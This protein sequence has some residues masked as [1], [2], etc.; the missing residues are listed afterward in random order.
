MREQ[1]ENRDVN[2]KQQNSEEIEEEEE[3]KTSKSKKKSKKGKKQEEQEEDELEQING[4]TEADHDERV[5]N[6]QKIMESFLDDSQIFRFYKGLT[7]NICQDLLNNL[8]SEQKQVRNVALDRVAVLSLIKFM[9]ISYK[10]CRENISYLFQLIDPKSPFANE[11]DN[12][13]KTNILV[14]LGDLYRRYTNLLEPYLPLVYQTLQDKNN[15]VR[16]TSLMVI[17]HLVLIDK[18]KVKAEVSNIATLIQDPHQPIQNQVKLFFY[19]INK[20]DVKQI[21][22]FLPDIITNLSKPEVN[23]EIFTEFAKQVLTTVIKE[24]PNEQMIEKMI[25]RFELTSTLKE[26]R[27]ISTVLTLFQYN[28]KS[29]KRL[30]EKFEF[31][32]QKLQDEKILENFQAIIKKTK[33]FGTKTPEIKALIEEFEAKVNNYKKETFDD[34]KYKK[35]KKPTKKDTKNKKQQQQK[36]RKSQ[37]IEM[38][39]E[40]DDSDEYKSRPRRKSSQQMQQRIINQYSGQQQ[41]N[42]KHSSRNQSRGRQVII[43]SESD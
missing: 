43:E 15:L 8:K 19:E 13:I 1:I 26:W 31:F 9:C 10:F 18:L 32:R 40:S 6:L 17:T 35:E 27:N 36:Q 3:Q 38:V 23:D 5:R 4:G 41:Q 14:G 7:K 39:L 22:N 29:I 24:T 2:K 11:L 42:I 30:L 34:Y 33:L 20:K 21:Y 25:Q 28:D 12:V 16:K 37:Q